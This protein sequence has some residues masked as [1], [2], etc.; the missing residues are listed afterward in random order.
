[1]G[2][3][4]NLL[5]RAENLTVFRGPQKIINNA[6]LELREGEIIVL[7]GENGC[8]KSTFI[9][10][11]ANMISPQKGTIVQTKPLFGLTLQQNGING[12]ELVNERML[13][14]MMV[15]NGDPADMD[16]VLEHWNML[17]RK[18]DLIAH[19]SFGMKR[20]IA[21]IQGLMPAYCSNSPKFCLLD[22][23]TEGLD[24]N[25]VEL[26]AND[27][28]TLASKGHGFI[29]ATHDS[30]ISKIATNICDIK[31]G[32]ISNN[33]TEKKGAF[34]NKL[35]KIN[36]KMGNAST[37]KSIWSGNIS[38]RTKLPLLKRGLPLI[39]SLLVIAGL[40]ME[41]NNENIPL[42]LVGGLIL[43]PGFLAALIK[44]AE[45]NYLQENRC[46][47]WW[48][49]MINEPIV[50]RTTLSEVLIVFFAPFITSLLV[51]DGSLPDDKIMMVFCSITILLV[52]YA[53]NAIYSLAENMP[54]RNS[55]FIP[56]LT[57]ILIWPFLITSDM[58]MTGEINNSIN[59][60]II[61]IV[62]PCI[63]Y[64][65]VPTLSKK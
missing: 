1:M 46:G 62:I 17:H 44:P 50:P 48:K 33:T 58:I 30:R 47:D 37:A 65:I 45:L 3:D 25:S 32:E 20:K 14:S 6:N 39:T 22:E 64:L 31:D 54:R 42:S 59:E 27:L 53:N 51:L 21:V 40:L 19:L 36:E 11:M 61:V 57:L 55:T 63:I 43:L 28:L 49:A 60:I 23:P 5:I 7:N 8:G 16:G 2:D 12:D 24:K 29:I 38:K 26:L 13:S 41:L 52:M 4:D 18:S 9:E 34:E 15:S 10:A 56:L 35:P